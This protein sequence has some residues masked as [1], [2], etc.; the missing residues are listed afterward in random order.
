LLP[1][2]FPPRLRTILTQNGPLVAIGERSLF[3]R[4][5]TPNVAQASVATGRQAARRGRVNRQPSP[6]TKR[7]SNKP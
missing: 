2:P 6:L 3:N 5:I 4:P 1:S 7:R